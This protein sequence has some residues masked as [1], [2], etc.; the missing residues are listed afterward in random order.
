MAEKA[1]RRRADTIRN[2]WKHTELLKEHDEAASSTDLT[3]FE[4]VNADEERQ[5]IEDAL[6]ELVTSRI[7]MT[8]GAFLEVGESALMQFVQMT[9]FPPSLKTLIILWKAMKILL[10]NLTQE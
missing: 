9:R 10:M 4:N 7:R 5:G 1:T 3:T 2:C 6:A 8:V